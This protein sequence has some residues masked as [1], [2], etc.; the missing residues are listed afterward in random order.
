MAE[1]LATHVERV[2][3]GEEPLHCV[4]L[5]AAREGWRRHDLE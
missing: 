4:N 3:R 5:E 2:A 1:V